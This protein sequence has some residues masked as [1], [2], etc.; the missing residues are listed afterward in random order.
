MPLTFEDYQADRVCFGVSREM[1]QQVL[2]DVQPMAID[3]LGLQAARHVLWDNWLP[4]NPVMTTPE[5][6]GGWGEL[7]PV[8][9]KPYDRPVPLYCLDN[10]AL[11]AGL[12]RE[13]FGLVS[14]NDAWSVDN[15]LRVVVSADILIPFLPT[16]QGMGRFLRHGA[17]TVLVGIC[18]L[19]PSARDAWLKLHAAGAKT[20][21]R[22]MA[23]I[24]TDAEID[25]RLTEIETNAFLAPEQLRVIDE[26]SVMAFLADE[27]R[28][29][30]YLLLLQCLCLSVTALADHYGVDWK[31]WVS[32]AISL[33]YQVPTFGLPEIRKWLRS[34]R[35]LS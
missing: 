8:W 22:D 34:S 3:A 18:W 26:D 14:K 11:F 30:T 23:D 1:V 24:H 6:N 20:F 16:T 29:R 35:K 32:Q 25:E 31:T 15:L 13:A 33:Q 19:D 21:A 5:T 4:I 10:W 28:Y 17:L 2:S 9:F 12:Y 27:S 7:M